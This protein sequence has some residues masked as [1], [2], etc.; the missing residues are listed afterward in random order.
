MYSIHGVYCLPAM[1]LAGDGA[2]AGLPGDTSS[3]WLASTAAATAP[4][5]SRRR[6]AQ[7]AG[8]RTDA[9]AMAV[10]GTRAV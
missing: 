1:E 7:A 4:R 3:S 10:G 9:A 5:A 8:A 6:S 2:G